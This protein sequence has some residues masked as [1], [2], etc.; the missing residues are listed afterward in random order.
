MKKPDQ[1]NT[2]ARAISVYMEIAVFPYTCWVTISLNLK[3]ANSIWKLCKKV[4]SSC[5]FNWFG[6]YWSL[7]F[8]ALTLVGA[9]LFFTKEEKK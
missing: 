8:Y 3:N 5:C 4:K 6:D 2:Y 7:R 9:F 1:L